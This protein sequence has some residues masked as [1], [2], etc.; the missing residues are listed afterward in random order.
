[1][2]EVFVLVRFL[3]IWLCFNPTLKIVGFLLIW[4]FQ[5][6]FWNSGVSTYMIVFQSHFRNSGV[7]TYM[8]V[9][10]SH[11]RN[12]GVSTYM[13]MFLSHFRNSHSWSSQVIM[14]FWHL[15]FWRTCMSK[16]LDTSEQKMWVLGRSFLLV[17]Y[18]SVHVDCIFVQ[19]F[20]CGLFCSCLQTSF[21]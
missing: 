17:V 4:L 14:M 13:I 21:F 15:I 18:I 9:F 20:N 5:S 19:D 12:S 8:I 6:H 16:V 2:R 7:S 3:L 11:F 10:Q 1:M